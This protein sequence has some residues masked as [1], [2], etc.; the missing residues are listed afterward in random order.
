MQLIL[1][2]NMIGLLNYIW[3]MTYSGESFVPAKSEVKSLC[4]GVPFQTISIAC[5]IVPDTR[6]WG[7]GQRRERRGV[8][9]GGTDTD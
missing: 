9:G 3:A 4:G 5:R 2:M 1:R 7:A 8:G 6:G